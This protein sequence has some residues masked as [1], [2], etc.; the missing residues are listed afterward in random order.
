M[1]PAIRKIDNRAVMGNFLGKCDEWSLLP[2]LLAVIN[3]G[4]LISLQ[5]WEALLW[6]EGLSLWV[7]I[8]QN[9]HSPPRQFQG[10]SASCLYNWCYMHSCLNSPMIYA[11]CHL[12]VPP[13]KQWS[14][15]FLAPRTSFM[16]DNFSMDQLR[17]GIVWRWFKRNTFIVFFISIMITL[18][19]PQI[20]RH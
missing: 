3:S 20:I 13:L 5:P 8:G 15:T 6:V 9:H 2:S 7:D 17:E 10:P 11:S 19:P 4:V 18:A 14:P 16:E 1:T 12:S